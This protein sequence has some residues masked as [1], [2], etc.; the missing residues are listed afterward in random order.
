MY[1]ITEKQRKEIQELISRKDK[2]ILDLKDKLKLQILATE[3]V[4]KQYYKNSSDSIRLYDENQELKLNLVQS[5][6]SH[7]ITKSTLSLITSKLNEAYNILECR[8]LVNRTNKIS[9]SEFLDI[10]A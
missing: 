2:E 8:G 4:S 9:T 6:K 1:S 10:K 5:E 7:N 3:E